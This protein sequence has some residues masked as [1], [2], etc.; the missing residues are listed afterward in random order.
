MLLE[1]CRKLTLVFDQGNG[2]SEE[3]EKLCRSRH[4]TCESLCGI[5]RGTDLHQKQEEGRDKYPIEVSASRWEDGVVFSGLN[6]YKN[7]ETICS[8][9]DIVKSDW[10]SIS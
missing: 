6:E 2:V 5:R 10:E 8:D 7:V 9:P 4:T 1:Q 3:S